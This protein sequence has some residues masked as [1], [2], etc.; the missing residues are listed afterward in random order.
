[1]TSV[2]LSVPFISTFRLNLASSGV[3][4]PVPPSAI[5]I[6]VIPVTEPPVIEISVES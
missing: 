4:A 1:M 2:E 3:D 5:V 6:S